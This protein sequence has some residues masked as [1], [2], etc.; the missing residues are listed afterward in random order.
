MV[1]YLVTRAV[2]LFCVLVACSVLTFAVFNVLP[3][4]NDVGSGSPARAP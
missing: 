2:W 1:R 3:A 4:R